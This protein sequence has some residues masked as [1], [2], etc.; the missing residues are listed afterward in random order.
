MPSQPVTNTQAIDTSDVLTETGVRERITEMAE[1]A[2]ARRIRLAVDT[3]DALMQRS[4]DYYPEFQCETVGSLL[5]VP[6]NP[7][8]QTTGVI[9]VTTVMPDQFPIDYRL[10]TPPPP[11]LRPRRRSRPTPAP[12]EGRGSTEDIYV[13]LM[14]L[15]NSMHAILKILGELQEDIKQLRVERSPMKFDTKGV[16]SPY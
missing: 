8:L 2:R 7:E 15:S 10:V 5:D 9:T 14:Y 1:D 6:H 4:S 11:P 12:T 16:K 13:E 3:F